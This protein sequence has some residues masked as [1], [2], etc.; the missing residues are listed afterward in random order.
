[1]FPV[2][3]RDSSERR[4]M[5]W[6]GFRL[7]VVT[8]EP[9]WKALLKYRA[10]K[11]REYGWATW[12]QGNAEHSLVSSNVEAQ[13]FPRAGD[14]LY[15]WKPLS[16]QL[17]IIDL[18]KPHRYIPT[19]DGHAHLYLETETSRWR[20][21]LLMLGLYVS[22]NI[23]KGFFWWSLRRGGNFVRQPGAFKPKPVEEV[24]VREPQPE[25]VLTRDFDYSWPVVSTL[26]EIMDGKADAIVDE[27]LKDMHGRA[28][29]GDTWDWV[30]PEIQTEIRNEWIKKVEDRLNG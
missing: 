10:K 9:F 13:D 23:E 24:E 19:S 20:W 14:G 12:H 18:D 6:W 11:D 4:R 22:G 3:I 16:R 26:E 15:K 25:D 28:G 1:M 7:D 29:L 5:K 30:P 2:A 17:P 27:L 21:W 8:D